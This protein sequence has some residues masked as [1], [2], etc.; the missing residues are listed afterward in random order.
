M[1]T[2]FAFISTIQALGKAQSGNGWALT[3]D[4]HMPDSTYNQIVN[5]QDWGEISGFGLGDKVKATLTRGNLKQ[6]KSGSKT[7]DYFWNLE[8]LEHTS[9]STPAPA[10][11]E[12]QAPAVS[13]DLR[14]A[15]N[16]AVN[17]AVQLHGPCPNAEAINWNG[18]RENAEKLYSLIVGGPNVTKV[19][20]RPISADKKAA[21]L[22][23]IA[24]MK[25]L[26]L[27]RIDE[28]G[29]ELA[30]PLNVADYIHDKYNGKGPRELTAAEIDEVIEAIRNG[31]VKDLIT[32]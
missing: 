13:V 6:G 9:E 28:D 8:S 32:F 18:L 25:E 7:Y 4:W 3:F 21:P 10:Q 15:W 20:D 26:N 19:S 14:I 30:S 5:G 29:E 2:S 11:R 17:N 1:D 24:K 12:A 27:A 16:S 22:A 31:D 23:G